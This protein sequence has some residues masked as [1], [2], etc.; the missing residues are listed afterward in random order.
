MEVVA[1]LERG[2]QRLVAGQVGHDAQLDLAVVGGQQG[3]VAGPDD[4]ALA[5]AAAGSVL[6]G[7]FCR[8]GSVE[9]SR[10]VAAIIWLKVVWMRPSSPVERSAVDERLELGDVAVAQQVLEHRVPGGG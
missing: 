6:I 7:M 8:L 2:A 1:G 4:E 3:L 5:D 9:D 10:P